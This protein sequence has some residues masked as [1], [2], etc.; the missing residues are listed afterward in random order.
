MDIHQLPCPTLVDYYVRTFE[1][2]VEVVEQSS[3]STEYSSDRVEESMA[4]HLL[5]IQYI[6][7]KF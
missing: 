1:T 5:K 2:V 4:Q 7:I 3:S 6:D